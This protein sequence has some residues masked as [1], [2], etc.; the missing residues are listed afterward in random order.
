MPQMLLMPDH[1]SHEV[2]EVLS[3][4][5]EMAREGQLTGIVFGVSF[6]GQKFYCDTAGSL[7][8]SP[9]IALGVAA[10]LTIQ[11]ERQLRHESTETI[12]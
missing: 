7:Y 5:M 12:I 3:G 6:K 1:S 9:V 4:L 8:R 2:S 11:I 10:M